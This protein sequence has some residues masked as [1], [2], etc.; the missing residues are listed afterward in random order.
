MENYKQLLK[1]INT[2]VFD[3]DGVLTN[4]IVYLLP[5]KD[6]IRTM[7]AKDSFA[8][9]Y[10][11]KKGYNIAVITGGN[12]PVVKERMEYLG[13]KDVY[14]Q[15]SDKLK[16]LHQYMAIK[17]ILASNILYMGDDLPDYHAMQLVK[18][19]ACPNDA[20]DEIKQIA[21]YIS[22]SKGGQGCVRDVIEQVLKVQNNWFD[23]NSLSW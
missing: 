16:Y 15:A 7:H 8:I 13:V 9:Q 17:N 19:A 4:G 23:K 10:A 5:P 20:A 11:V 18:I 12:S 2:F 14:L 21:H 3:F 22:P 1:D 6:F